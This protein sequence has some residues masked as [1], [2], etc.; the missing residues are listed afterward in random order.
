M[1][2][3]KHQIIDKIKKLLAQHTHF[4]NGRP[5]FGKSMPVNWYVAAVS[6]CDFFQSVNYIAGSNS[7]D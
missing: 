1:V 5:K 7:N 6:L 2:R 4:I 3:E